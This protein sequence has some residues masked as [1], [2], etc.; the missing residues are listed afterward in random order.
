MRGDQQ[1]I[2]EGERFPDDTHKQFLLRAKTN[3]TRVAEG[4]QTLRAPR[5]VA[6]ADRS[7]SMADDS[8]GKRLT[9]PGSVFD[10]PAV[11]DYFAIVIRRA[12]DKP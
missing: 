6:A 8:D 10:V 2:I 12:E 3:Y 9:L 11:L 7:P 5:A 4:G 1:D